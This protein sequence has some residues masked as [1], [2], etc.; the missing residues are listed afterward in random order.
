MTREEITEMALKVLN[1][2][3]FQEFAKALHQ[4]KN[5]KA[6]EVAYN[7]LT[8]SEALV[9]DSVRKDECDFVLMSHYK[10]SYKLVEVMKGGADETN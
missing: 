5:K 9:L 8:A 4:N 7:E 3:E 10:Q 2:D 6:L 1:R